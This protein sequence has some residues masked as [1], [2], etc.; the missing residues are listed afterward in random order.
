MITPAEQKTLLALARAGLEG[1]PG[2]AD[3]SPA[4][5]RPAGAFVTLHCDGTLR[6]CIGSPSARPLAQLVVEL[7]VAAATQDPRFPPVTNAEV[8]TLHIEISVLGETRPIRRVAHI[9]V[10]RHGL[11]VGRGASQGLLLPQV[12]TEQGWDAETF[13]SRTCLKSGLPEDAWR[14]WDAG[15][16]SEFSV[17]TFTAQVFGEKTAG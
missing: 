9:E 13:L 6:G 5:Q 2:D 12:A 8:D 10:G 4:L 17:E 3:I 14:Q 1:G 11:I 16:D 7:A 15:K